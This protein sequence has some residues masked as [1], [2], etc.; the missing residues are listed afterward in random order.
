[1]IET[2]KTGA[3]IVT[4][5]GIQLYKLQALKSCLELQAKTGMQP[6]RHTN[7]RKIAK[8][9]FKLKTNDFN[10]LL[11]ACEK[12]IAELSPQVTRVSEANDST[13]ST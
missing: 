9:L 3:V 4:G 2:T 7:P 6:N 5:K 12:A 8:Q 11:A 1:V 10:V 13:N